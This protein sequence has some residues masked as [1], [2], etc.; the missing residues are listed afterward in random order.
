MLRD[1]DPPFL[2][3]VEIE[4]KPHADHEVVVRAQRLLAAQLEHRIRAKSRLAQTTN[5]GV[6]LL[7]R[8]TQVGI[9]GQGARDELVDRH[10]SRA[11]LSVRAFDAEQ[12]GAADH[13][14]DCASQP[15]GHLT[16][17]ENF[18]EPLPAGPSQATVTCLEPLSGKVIVPV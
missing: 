10:V 5:G 3:P 9:I 17:T 11:A 6:D 12:H 8:G 7:A 1:T 18:V 16:G 14:H 13:G 4:R 2:A 15:G